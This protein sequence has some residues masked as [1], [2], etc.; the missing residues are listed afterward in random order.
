MLGH[1]IALCPPCALAASVS[2]PIAL[3]PSFLLSNWGD[4]VSWLRFPSGI[5]ALG[6]LG[7]SAYLASYL[8]V[9]LKYPHVLAMPALLDLRVDR[10]STMFFTVGLD[11]LQQKQ[12][13]KETN[14]T[15]HTTRS[16][17]QGTFYH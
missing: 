17:T 3:Y 7:V 1:F 16:D 10:L 5:V 13:Q 15:K 8:K 2:L 12:N 4:S 9:L 14:K 6:V 11:L